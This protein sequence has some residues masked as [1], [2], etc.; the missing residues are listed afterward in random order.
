VRVLFLLAIAG[1]VGASAACSSAGVSPP[2]D[3]GADAEPGPEAEAFDRLVTDT[4]GLLA[5]THTPGASIAVVL[6]GKLA[7]AAGI[8]SRNLFNGTPVTTST[9]FR[10]GSM[11]KMVVAATAMTLVD[12]GKLDLA[13]PITS[14]VPW[15][16]LAGGFDA[17]KITMSALLSHSS[18][19]PCDTIPMCG[20]TSS[21]PRQ[22]FFAA[23]PQPLWAPPGA[24]YDYS[25]AGF[26]LA[27]TVIEAA[28]GANDGDFERLAHDRVFAP[29]NMA[30]ASFDAD[31]ATKVDHATGYTLDANG[32]VTTIDEPNQAACPLMNP[33]GGVVATATDYAHFAEMLLAN[34]G[35][36]LTPSSVAAMEAPHANPRTIATQQ[37]G[38]GLLTQ[39]SPYPDHATVWHNGS[40]TGFTSALYMVPDEQFAIVALVNVHS[41]NLV[42]ESIVWDAMRLFIPEPQSAAKTSTPPA[43]WTGYVGTYDDPYGTLGAGVSVSLSDGGASLLVNAP[44]ANWSG[45][46]APVSGA[47]T[48]AAIDAWVMP[49]GTLA[50]FFPGADGGIGYFVTRRGVGV[51]P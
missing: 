42:V 3:A 17:S 13:A 19:F 18:G 47:M 28:A 9:L 29:A 38:Y 43:A 14:Y 46:P 50:T 31:A 16:H 12:Q 2:V 36:V 25:N 48:Q 41:K 35:A 45:T 7:F 10:A 8:G 26:S 27:A 40:I 24:I 20:P 1:A 51:R 37:Y 44:N 39:R 5:R 15:F 23:N 21:G 6:H 33:P 49:E 11:S 4:Q 34:G 22:A 32:Q 30:T